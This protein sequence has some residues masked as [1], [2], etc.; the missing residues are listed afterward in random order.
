MTD[1]IIQHPLVAFGRDVC[2][3]LDGGMRREWLVTNGL[4]G[5]A[6]STVPGVNTRRYHGLLVAAL[7]P[8]VGRTVLVGN[9]VEWA[10]Y[11]GQRYAL[12][13]HEF[14]DGTI[15]PGGYVHLQSFTL[16]GT[17]PVWVFALGDALLE[18]RLWMVHGANTTCLTYRLIRGMAPIDLDITPLVTYRDFHTLTS[19]HGWCPRVETAAEGIVV[20]AG[21]DAVPLYLGANRGEFVSGG[22]WYW[23]FWHREEAARGL[24]ARS[25]LFAPGM[26]RATLTHDVALAVCLAAE[27]RPDLD[28]GRALVAERGRQVALLGRSGAELEEPAVQQLVLAADQFLVE[29]RSKPG[30]RG[31]T[32]VAGYHWF[33]DWGRD[34]M[35]AVPGL[36]L[37]T[38]RPDDAARILRSF[39]PYVAAGLL[40]NNFADRPDADPDYNTVDA[41]LWYVLAVYAYDRATGNSVL[42][43]DLLPVVRQIVDTY[44]AGTR[45]GIVMDPADGLLRAG[46]PGVPLTWM[47]A[48]IGDRVVTPR[49][50]KPVEVNAL[51]Y[52]TLRIVAMLAR[53]RGDMDAVTYDRLSA[54]VKASFRKRFVPR[55][56]GSLADV[57]DGPDGDDWTLRPNQ[58]LAVSLPSPLLEG[59]EAAAVVA[60]VGRELLTTY[61]LRSLAPGDPTYHGDCAGDQPHRDEAYHQGTAWTW[62]LGA[63]AEAHYRTYHD[64]VALAELLRPIEA[65]LRDAGLGTISEIFAGDPPHAPRGCI[66]QAWSVAEILRV[67]RTYA[68]QVR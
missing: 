22:D 38:G 52:N 21:N 8:P 24:D 6:S 58:I 2:G 33:N 20:H 30:G 44:V 47:D 29:R 35:M 13:T 10:T 4:G 41:A 9:T 50:G 46:E 27:S 45:F 7:S 60:V 67:W 15:H 64:R 28:V 34:A 31:R 59:D 5:Y 42:A 14:A 65:H 16:D 26:F 18:R 17:L 53:R 11:G 32:I 40:P 37:T 49:I 56:G 12:S 62:L 1:T 68:R 66:A 57:V 61:G 48:K 39:A 54:Q 19:G 3:H 51:W 55:D 23:N 36:C 25:D 43:A 63:Y